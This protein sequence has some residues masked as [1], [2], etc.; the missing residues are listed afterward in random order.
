MLSL[1]LAVVGQ[2]LI[3]FRGLFFH[4]T[5][6]QSSLEAVCVVRRRSFHS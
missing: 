5:Q 2:L 3:H 6:L 1:I 4:L